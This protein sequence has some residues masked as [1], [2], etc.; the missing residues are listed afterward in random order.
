M[1]QLAEKTTEEMGKPELITGMIRS[2]TRTVSRNSTAQWD[3]T[4]LRAR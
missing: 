1:V 2:L 3:V 4:A